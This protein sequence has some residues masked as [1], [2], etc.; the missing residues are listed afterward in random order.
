MNKYFVK[1]YNMQQMTKFSRNTINFKPAAYSKYSIAELCSTLE[2]IKREQRVILRGDNA[3]KHL[4]QLQD[5]IS[6]E[7]KTTGVNRSNT[8]SST[9]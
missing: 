1:S 8:L 5:K 9:W 3:V 6:R 4:P 2:A 7:M